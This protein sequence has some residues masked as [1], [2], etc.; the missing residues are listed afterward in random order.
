MFA[1]YSIIKD[2]KW[3]H[4]L[5]LVINI[6]LHLNLKLLEYKKGNL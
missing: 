1:K 4:E 6:K 3:Q 2:K 5:C